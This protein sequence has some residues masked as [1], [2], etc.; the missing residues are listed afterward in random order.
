M[1]TKE[2]KQ[3]LDAL[4]ITR[5]TIDNK[6][7]D[8]KRQIAYR[9]LTE[10]SKFYENKT[11]ITKD[12]VKVIVCDISLKGIESLVITIRNYN[13]RAESKK[14]KK[15]LSRFL[16]SNYVCTNDKYGFIK[17]KHNIFPYKK[18]E[19][20]LRFDQDDIILNTREDLSMAENSYYL[21][22]LKQSRNEQV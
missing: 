6:I 19:E 21:F 22:L 7:I 17:I 13:C 20:E 8:L 9:K 1:E 10:V 2:L 4:M 18:E 16:E 15:E 3:E 5:E 14:F 12:G 11:F